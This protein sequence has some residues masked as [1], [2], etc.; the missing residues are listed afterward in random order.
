MRVLSFTTDYVPHR[1]GGGHPIGIGVSVTVS[2]LHDMYLKNR[3][4]D[5]NQMCM[6]ITLGHDEELIRLG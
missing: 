2:C 4:A 1:I 3:S 6:D 5:L